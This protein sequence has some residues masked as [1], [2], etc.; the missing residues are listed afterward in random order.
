MQ[1]VHDLTPHGNSGIYIAA[2]KTNL[3]RLVI[4]APDNGGVI[5][6]IAC[7]PAGLVIAGGA[8]FARNGNIALVGSAA[9]TV[10]DSPLQH[11]VDI[12][13]RFCADGS[14][15]FLRIVKNH[16]SLRIDDLCI[17]SCLAENAA[18]GEGGIGLRHFANGQTVSQLTQRKGSVGNIGIM[19]SADFQILNQS[20]NSHFLRQEVV[21]VL[22][23][24][25][26][27]G[28]HGYRIERTGQ[29]AQNRTRTA[30]AS[31]VVLG[32]VVVKRGV[33][34]N[35]ARR[36]NT[37]F[38]S[39]SVNSNRLNGGA[40]R[41][42]ALCCTVQGKASFLFSDTAGHTDDI[43]GSVIDQDD[44]RLKLL[45]A[46]GSGNVAGIFVDTVDNGLCFGVDGAVDAVAAGEKLLHGRI[47][48]DIVFFAKTVD[49]ITVDGIHKIGVGVV[50]IYRIVLSAAVGTVIGIV[51][52]M[53]IAAR[54]IK[55]AGAASKGFFIIAAVVEQHFLRNGKIIIAV[56]AD[57]TLIVHFHQ[58]GKL[59]FAVVLR[60][61]IRIIE[62]RIVG[63]GNDT[64]TFGGGQLAD[65][66]AEVDL[67]S[68]LHAVAALAEIDG[69]QIPFH[70]LVFGIML[71]NGQ[72][73]EDLLHLTVDGDIILL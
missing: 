16:I 30:V 69:V 28:F 50:V 18:V 51:L 46:D 48:A 15:A 9:G 24:E 34:Q 53:I 44:C 55:T 36:D 42:L 57:I 5:R 3:L 73:A 67:R 14:V 33:F 68:A 26:V 39:G 45:G 13:I 58:D 4:A 35:G 52:L 60:V 71:L 66:L 2:G 40:D 11:I 47:F 12:E 20:G 38:Q 72:C 19:L 29:T 21:A 27:K 7:K 31:G 41:Q 37:G 61:D 23:T 25:P 59:T 8:G 54:P 64:G 10:G 22:R 70:N 65:I 63:N 56:A 49:Y 1:R 62:R 6:G 43:A 17:G 32:P